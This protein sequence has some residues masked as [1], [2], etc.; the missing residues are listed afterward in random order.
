MAALYLQ[1]HPRL[2]SMARRKICP[3][4]GQYSTSYCTEVPRRGPGLLSVHDTIYSVSKKTAQG[5]FPSS[6]R[7]MHGV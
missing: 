2:L 3:D 5:S 1:L 7:T 6:L 4:S